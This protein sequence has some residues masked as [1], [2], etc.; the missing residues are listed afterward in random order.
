MGFAEQVLDRLG[1][2]LVLHLGG[3]A[4]DQAAE[5][6]LGWAMDLNLVRDDLTI[7]GGGANVSFT[8]YTGSGSF[9]DGFPFDESVHQPLAEF[10]N[11]IQNHGM[12]AWFTVRTHRH[13]EPDSEGMPMQLAS[14]FFIQAS[15]TYQDLLYLLAA[16]TNP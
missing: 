16:E 3:Q 4:L 11:L 14:L 13:E 5:F 9:A 6:V 1:R 7:S 2:D 15:P 12:P 10:K 8:T